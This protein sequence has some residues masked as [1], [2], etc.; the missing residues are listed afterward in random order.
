MGNDLFIPSAGHKFGNLT[1]VAN[2]KPTSDSIATEAGMKFMTD[3]HVLLDLQPLEREV[4]Y[5]SYQLHGS[6]CKRQIVTPDGA[7]Q[8]TG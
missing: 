1:A 4:L 2:P 7:N 6:G 3:F 5:P 8:G